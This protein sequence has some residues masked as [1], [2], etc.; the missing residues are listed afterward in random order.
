MGTRAGST[1]EGRTGSGRSQGSRHVTESRSSSEGVSAGS[2]WP[3]LEELSSVHVHTM[4]P[5]RAQRRAAL[6]QKSSWD[7]A[8]AGELAS[9]SKIHRRYGKSFL[10]VTVYGYQ[11]ATVFTSL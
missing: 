3:V 7:S 5:V 6:P 10:T 9:T 11:S 4:A 8:P 1:W 2:P